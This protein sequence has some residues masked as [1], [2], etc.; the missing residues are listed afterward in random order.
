[1]KR[2]ALVEMQKANEMVLREREKF[3]MLLKETQ[4]IEKQNDNLLENCWNCGRKAS[5]TC[6]GCRQAKYCSQFCQHKNW[7]WIHHKQCAVSKNYTKKN[8]S[9]SSILA[10]SSS[11]VTTTNANCSSSS[12]ATSETK[13]ES[14]NLSI[15]IKP[16]QNENLNT[17]LNEKDIKASTSSNNNK[18][19]KS[20]S[21]S[22]SSSSS[23]NSNRNQNDDE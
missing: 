21:S 23:P 5:E 1:M 16:D 13:K 6:G 3:D 8:D 7:E 15:E 18:S 19:P 20:F 17:S 12:T 14:L 9:N 4:A 2:Q 11:A 10:T 22:R